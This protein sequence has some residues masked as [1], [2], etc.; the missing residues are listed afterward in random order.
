MVVLAF[1][2]LIRLPILLLVAVIQYMTRYLVIEPMLH[3]NKLDL[4]ITDGQFALLVLASIL[5]GGGGYAINDY[6]DVKIDR[7]NKPKKIIVGRLIKRRVAMATHVV[8]TVLGL[9]ISV[10]VSYK[11]GLWELSTFFILASFLLWYYSTHLQHTTFWGNF[12]TAI[13]AAFAPLVVGLYEIP[14]QNLRIEEQISHLRYSPLN[15]IAF[16]ILGY[17]ALIGILT[18]AREITKDVIDMR[19]DKYYDLRTVPVV[20]GVRNS[21]LIIMS[22]YV[23]F[24]LVL[25]YFYLKNAAHNVWFTYMYAVLFLLA[26]IQFPLLYKARTKPHFLMSANMNV[27]TVMVLIG[28]MFVINYMLLH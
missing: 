27:V 26:L 16:W 25:S 19:G 23:L 10:G 2:R 20:V 15:T 18:L 4:I 28:T 13:I 21:K 24:G 1:L 22:V 12:V 17:S 9:L 8:M 11:V 14:L 3:L 6:F 5:I 7:I